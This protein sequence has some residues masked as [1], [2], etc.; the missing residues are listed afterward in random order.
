MSGCKWHVHTY[1]HACTYTHTLNVSHGRDVEVGGP[2]PHWL[3][4]TS[5]V[6]ID[7]ASVQEALCV[8]QTVQQIPL[9]VGTLRAGWSHLRHCEHAPVREAH[10]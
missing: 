3:R 7:E 10:A 2:E 1:V 5:A 9:L 8:V 4:G 6:A